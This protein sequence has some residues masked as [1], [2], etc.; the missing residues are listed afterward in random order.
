MNP[1]QHL[2]LNMTKAKYG[3]ANA[4]SHEAALVRLRDGPRGL[5]AKVL[6]ILHPALKAFGMSKERGGKA[7]QPVVEKKKTGP[8]KGK[9]LSIDK[10]SVGKKNKA[11]VAI[12]SN[13]GRGGNL[14]AKQLNKKKAKGKNSKGAADNNTDME[15]D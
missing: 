2:S 3:K 14:T 13:K 9:Q 6:E 4:D 11:A 12:I 1:L 15:S 10:A 7:A 5:D 8:N